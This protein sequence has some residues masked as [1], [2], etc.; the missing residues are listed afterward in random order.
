MSDAL[1][2]L[3]FILASIPLCCNLDESF[4]TSSHVPIPL[5]DE[6]LT[7]TFSKFANSANFANF[8][9]FYLKAMKFANIICPYPEPANNLQIV[10]E[11]VCVLAL[12]RVDELVRV[13]GYGLCMMQTPGRVS[14][15]FKNSNRAQHL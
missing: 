7:A 10:F 9:K 1:T 2:I 12:R 8:A 14:W 13:Q 5:L 15:P 4:D 6:L 11:R 3:L